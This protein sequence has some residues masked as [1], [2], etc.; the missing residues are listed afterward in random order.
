[1][2]KN[3]IQDG[4]TISFP[5][6]YAVESGA[7][8]LIGATFGVS[9]AKLASGEVGQFSLEDVWQLPKATGA[10]ANLG[11]KAYWNDTNKNV[12]ASSSGNTLIGVFVPA[13]PAQTTAYASGDTLANVRLHGA[14]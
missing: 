5:A 6:P 10:A 4:N 13:T 11:A 3:F 2:A 9:L 12:T 8:A 1:M 7:G 14:F